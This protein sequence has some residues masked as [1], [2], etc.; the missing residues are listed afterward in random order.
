MGNK[1][2]LAVNDLSV[3][4]GGLKA[5]SNINL[6]IQSSE[7]VGLIGPNGAG[8]TTF[9]NALTGLCRPTS[10]NIIFKNTNLERKSAH[11]ICQQGI[12][13]TFQNIRLFKSLSVIDNLMIAGH[14]NI[15]YPLLS[16]VLKIPAYFRDE[17]QATKHAQEM[18]ELVGLGKQQNE[19]SASLPYGDQR[20]LEIAR[21]LV[22]NPELLLLDEPAAGMNPNE[23]QELVNLIR[24]VRT[25]LQITIVLIEHDMNLVMNLCER[26]IVL[27]Y[28]IL[29]AQGT[30]D[31]IRAN[32]KVIEAYLGDDSQWQS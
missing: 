15:K 6:E 10:G 31:E 12:A 28:G 21:A 17:K 24:K 20:K 7:L 9:F 25:E 1:S 5:V 29:I 11:F 27:D 19:M 26:I 23:T 14:Q 30:V 18:L 32:P 3:Q 4:F 2:S 22:T 8:K 13:R 16:S